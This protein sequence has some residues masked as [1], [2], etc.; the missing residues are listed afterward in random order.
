MATKKNFET[1]GNNVG[2]FVQNAAGTKRA[3]PEA[4]PAEKK[5]RAASGKT[6]GKKGCKQVR[7]NLAFTTDNHEFI[8]I[9]S[10]ITGRTMT[11]FLNYVIEEYRKEHSEV[12]EQAKALI[13]K[14]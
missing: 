6:Q 5:A 1:I 8:A 4:S 12:F 13:G 7:I 2:S 14:A 10:K 9:M 3:Q 11:G